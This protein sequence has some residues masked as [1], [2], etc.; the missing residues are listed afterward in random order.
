VRRLLFLFLVLSNASLAT[1]QTFGGSLRGR[2]EMWDWFDSPVA[3]GSYKYFGAL[4]RGAIADQGAGFGWRVE[5]AVPVLLGLPEEAVGPAPAGQLGG[6]ASYWQASDSAENTATIF[7][8]QAFVRFGR[9]QAQG[10]HSLRLGRFE[11]IE[12]AEFPAKN[13]TVAAVKRD[14]IAH[15]MIGN[16]GWTHVQRSYDG[17][18]YGFDRASFN[19][20]LVALRPTRGVF[21]VKGMENLD[22]GIAYA[23]VNG[24]MSGG[25][26]DWRLFAIGYRDYRDD[27]RPVKTDNRP[28]AARVADAEDVQVATLGGHYVRAI[29]T[30]AGVIDLMLWG[31]VQAGAWGTLDH[32]ANAFAGEAGVQPKALS[33]LK[34]WLRAGYLRSS[35]DEDASDGEHKTFFQNTPTPR[36]YARFPFYNLMNLDDK[37]LSLQLRPTAKLT[38]RADSRWLELTEGTD[39][40]YAGG[41]AFEP[42]TFGYAGRPANGAAELAWLL[43]LSVDFRWSERVSINGYGA[44]AKAGDAINRI[45]LSDASLAYIEFE[46]RK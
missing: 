11:F 28:L 22:V 40:W 19:A 43:D 24:T 13:P 23:S 34:P 45:F 4:G 14:R 20:S 9:P 36:I 25:A 6:G 10:G 46:I 27:P 15:R 37:S 38:L 12:G 5:A 17:A 16:F 21:D 39:L 1:A 33:A 2:V 3:G 29:Q 7:L 41:G 30:G 8:K 44:I 26:A 31:A 35:G 18:Q 32:S 42:E